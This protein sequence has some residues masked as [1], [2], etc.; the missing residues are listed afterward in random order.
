MV[1]ACGGDGDTQHILI[2]IDRLDNGAQEEQEL[3]V[4][5]GGFARLKQVYAGVGRYRPVIVFAAAVDPGKGLLVEQADHVVLLCD[6]LHYLHGE[7]VVICGNIGG[8]EDGRHFVLSGGD[9]IMLGLG[10]HADLP[11]LVV[12]LLHKCG[13]SRLDSA[14]VMVV[15]LLTLGRS[16]AEK[17]SAGIYKVF[18]LIVELLVNKEVFLLGADGGLDRGDILVAEELQH[19]HRLTVDGFH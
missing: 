7:L 4:L 6:L 19:S 14:E 5:I 9:L 13:D 16:C 17:G 12:Q 11:K 15:K 2:F 1:V 8:G 18:S 10:K 3:S